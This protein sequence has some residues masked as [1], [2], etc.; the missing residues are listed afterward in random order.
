M[1]EGT[2][3]IGKWILMKRIDNIWAKG[4]VLVQYELLLLVCLRDPTLSS[5]EELLQCFCEY[6]TDTT[7]LT[8][9]AK[10]IYQDNGKLLVLLLDGCDGLPEDLRKNSLLLNCQ[11]LPVCSLTVSSASQ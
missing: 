9:R 7:S 1:N 6:R 2:P 10:S 8:V 5:A 3:G 11:T 4:E